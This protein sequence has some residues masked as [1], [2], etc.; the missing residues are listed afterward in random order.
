MET[1]DL[2]LISVFMTGLSA[3]KTLNDKRIGWNQYSWKPLFIA[4]CL[5]AGVTVVRSQY[6]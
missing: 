5:V 3:F 6:S 2:L 1:T 4:G